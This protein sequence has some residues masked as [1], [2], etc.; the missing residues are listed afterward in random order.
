MYYVSIAVLMAIFDFEKPTKVGHRTPADSWSMAYIQLKNVKNDCNSI[1]QGH[2]MVLPD[3]L[4]D[5]NVYI[6]TIML[7]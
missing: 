1:L 6:R 7:I 2:L 5:Q 3:Y 4:V